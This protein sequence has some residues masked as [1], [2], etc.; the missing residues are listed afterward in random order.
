VCEHADLGHSS[1]ACHGSP[2]ACRRTPATCAEFPV[3]DLEVY[4]ELRQDPD[5]PRSVSHDA[6]PLADL[7]HDTPRAS[8]APAYAGIVISSAIRRLTLT[9]GRL[10]QAS[11]ATPEPVDDRALEAA[12]WAAAHEHR[13]IQTCQRRWANLPEPIRHELPAVPHDHQA[14]SEIAWRARQ[15]RDELVRLREDL[16]VEDHIGVAEQL[17]V[18]AGQLAQMPAQSASQR[19]HAAR[20]HDVVAETVGLTALRDLIASPEAQGEVASWLH[21]R[22]FNQPDHAGLYQVITDLRR[23]RMPVDPVTVSWQAARRGITIEPQKLSGGCGAFARAS[24]AQ[25]Y[26]R[27]VLAQ[28]QQAGL[29][30]QA[31]AADPGLPVANIL[32]PA[33]WRLAAAGHDLT[34]ARCQA[35]GRR[36][37]VLALPAKGK[38]PIHE[39]SARAELEW[40]AAQ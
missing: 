25:V 13:D 5:L 20:P 12:R 39:G 38:R 40:E 15:V 11:Q 2:A 17:A 6:V 27:A 31:D 28:V 34:P 1:P 26:R 37:D 9:G 23:A 30:I 32:R 19:H 16:W 22:H 29:D 33:D 24:T 21:P 8:H 36:A 35:P 7:M 3:N 14:H 18:I 10:R 4:A